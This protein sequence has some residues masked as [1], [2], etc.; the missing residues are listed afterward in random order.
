MLTAIVLAACGGPPPPRPTVALV[1]E[2]SGGDR[3]ALDTAL[4]EAGARLP[5]TLTARALP[6]APSAPTVTVPDF[7][8]V[9]TAYDEG[10]LEGCLSSLPDGAAMLASLERGDRTTASRSS[11]WRMACLRALG[12]TDEALAVARDH[13]SRHLPLPPDVGAANPTAET[14][15]RDV[16]REVSASAPRWVRA[17]STPPGASI[18]IDGEPSAQ[19]TPAD[20]ALSPGAHL[21]TLSLPTYATRSAEVVAADEA[22]SLAVTL[23]PL[24]PEPA[25]S[26]LHD[27]LARGM[28]LDADVSLALLAISL[29]A[30]SLVLVSEDRDRVRAALIGTGD[31]GG[32]PTIVRAER[33]G[34]QRHD[35]EGL[36]R[37][38]LVRAQLAAPPPAFYELPEV[39]IAVAAA[40]ALAVG[41]TLGLTLQPDVHTR[42]VV[43]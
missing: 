5:V 15:L 21:I 14:M 32:T 41:V 42:L 11:F 8:A 37:D 10:D 31:E 16:E 23:T 20:L 27:A 26:A 22:A 13:A 36:V 19:T 40:V 17:V 3:A 33:V 35:L 1:A 29:R 34:E 7:A 38:V 39:W 18:A 30:R 43:P 28:S 4:R 24:E 9:R 12:R 6:D 2:T 25:A